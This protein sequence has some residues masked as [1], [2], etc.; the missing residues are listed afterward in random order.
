[1]CYSDIIFMT[2]HTFYSIITLIFV[3]YILNRILNYLANDFYKLLFGV[4]SKSV[5]WFLYD[6]GLHHES[7]KSNL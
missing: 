5:D 6:N 4:R 1:M 2:F 7:L 3:F